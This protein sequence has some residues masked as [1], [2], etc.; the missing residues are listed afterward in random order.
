M[1]AVCVK[2]VADRCEPGD[3]RFAGISEADQAALELALRQAELAAT[4]G[5]HHDVVVVTAGPPSAERAL[6]DALADGATSAIRIDLPTAGEGAENRGDVPSIVVAAALAEAVAGAAFVWCGDLSTDRGSG[7]VPAFLAACLG[8]AQA[9]GGVAVQMGDEPGGHQVVVTRRL[10]GGRREVVG[11][12]APAVISVEGAAARLRRAALGAL[13][14]ARRAP[15]EQ[16]HSGA[17]IRAQSIPTVAHPYRPRAREL[18]APTGTTLQRLRALT[19]SAGVATHGETVHL[20]PAAAAH[21]IVEALS[22][23]GYSPG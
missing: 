1:I 8:A 7:S 18:P 16:R 6:R 13:L 20:D 4:R 14:A 10:D 12:K 5:E 17:A 2:W 21:R 11:V 15:V 9:L 23:W 19:D 3:D 22:E